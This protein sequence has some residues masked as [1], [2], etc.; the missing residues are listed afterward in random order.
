MPEDEEEG[1][2]PTRAD[3][4]LTIPWWVVVLLVSLVATAVMG[5]LLWIA[6]R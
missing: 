2:M 5:G 1:E 3:L 6:R 4:V